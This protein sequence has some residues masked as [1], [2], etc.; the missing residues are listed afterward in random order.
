MRAEYFANAPEFLAAVEPWLLEREAENNVVLS[1]A[2][3]IAQGDH[4]FKE[5]YMFAAVLDGGDVV[6]AALRP[7]PDQLE[8]S[9]MPAGAATLLTDA[10]AR[11]Y[12]DLSAVSGPP[13]PALEFADAW[14]ARSGRAWRLRYRWGLHV[15]RDVVPPRP[16]EGYLRVGSPAEAPLLAE[17]GERYGRELDS[18][19]DVPAFFARML[20]RGS[21]YLWDHGGPRSLVAVSGIT[22][23]GARIAAVY[24]PEEYRNRGYASNAVATVTRALI[25]GGREFCTLFAEIEHATPLRIYRSIGFHQLRENLLIEL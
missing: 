12:P 7:P 21:L 6:G 17:W 9:S 1:V 24:T 3:L 5:P 20:R 14:S 4:P 8:L 16:C 10:A 11:L 25:D 2:R 15:A 19:V 13:G 22:P 23:R 18:K